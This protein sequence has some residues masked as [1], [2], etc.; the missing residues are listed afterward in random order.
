M[1]A[2]VPINFGNSVDPGC[3]SIRR[4]RSS[5]TSSATISKFKWKSGELFTTQVWILNDKP[6]KI[7]AGKL[8][9]TIVSIDQTI[10]LGS[11]NYDAAEANTN[12]QGPEFSMV[13]PVL[14]PGIFKL[15]LEVENRPGLNSEYTMLI[16]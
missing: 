16:E 4:F 2:D 12:L 15:I 13:L 14:K 6:D 5:R 3:R 8:K 9:A 7:G 10:V 11:W 1:V